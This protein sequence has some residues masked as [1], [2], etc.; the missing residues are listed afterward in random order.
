[1]TLAKLQT[2]MKHSFDK[3]NEDLKEVHQAL[4]KYGKALDKVRPSWSTP[5]STLAD[6]LSRN[7]KISLS[8]PPRTMP[9]PHTRPWSTVPSP[10][11]YSVRASLA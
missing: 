5:S 11:I 6:S 10:C 1:M 3:V 8:R 2:P 4:G 9:F 7:S